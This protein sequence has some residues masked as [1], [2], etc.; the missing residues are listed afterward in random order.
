MLS[1]AF[2]GFIRP[3]FYSLGEVFLTRHQLPEA[4]FRFA[5]LWLFNPAWRA[6]AFSA[7][8]AR[9]ILAMAPPFLSSFFFSFPRIGKHQL[10]GG[11][12]A[13]ASE[14]GPCLLFHFQITLAFFS[15]NLFF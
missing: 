9:V 2:D 12:P 3:Q 11:C 13:A 10:I 6:Q 4:L 7:G 14:F 1:L 15:Y 5:D 8:G